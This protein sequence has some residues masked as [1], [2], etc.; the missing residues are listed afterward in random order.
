MSRAFIKE[1]D[2]EDADNA[3]AARQHSPHMNYVTPRGFQQLQQRVKQ[4]MERK[5]ELARSTALAEQ[6]Q[7]KPLERELRYYEERVERAVLITPDNQPDDRVHFGATVEV[8]DS[9][10]QTAQYTLVGEDEA[11]ATQGLISWVSPLAVAL[12]DAEVG[13]VVQWKRP[14][15]DKELEV[16][17]LR[18]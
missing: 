13:D 18:K 3:A 14:L 7:L 8:R 16:I 10:G 4:L 2:F 9:D 17:A 6:Q 1:T 5:S 12:M 15:G 11:D